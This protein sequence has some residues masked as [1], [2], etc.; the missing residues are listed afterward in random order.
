MDTNAVDQN[1]IQTTHLPSFASHRNLFSHRRQAQ[2][3]LVEYTT[4]SCHEATRQLCILSFA[5]QLLPV[6]CVQ[7]MELGL[8]LNYLLPRDQLMRWLKI[9]AQSLVLVELMPLLLDLL[10]TWKLVVG[11]RQCNH[12][13]STVFMKQ[14][15]P[16]K[17]CHFMETPAVAGEYWLTPDSMKQ[18]ILQGHTA[19]QEFTHRLP[20]CCRRS[21]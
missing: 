6:L 12:R 3:C 18:A 20:D 11:V 10:T 4:P 8:L 1:L 2:N 16:T 17:K 19:L 9:A 13:P 5:G 14:V 15:C 21:P 7:Q